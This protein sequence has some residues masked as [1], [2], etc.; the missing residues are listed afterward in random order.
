M[1]PR[2]LHAVARLAETHLNSPAAN[3]RLPPVVELHALPPLYNAAAIKVRGDTLVVGVPAQRADGLHGRGR[4]ALG[5]W[6]LHRRRLRRRR[7]GGAVARLPV[8]GADVA[9]GLLLGGPAR[10]DGRVLVGDVGDGE[11]EESH[12]LRTLLLVVPGAQA[13]MVVTGAVQPQHVVVGPVADDRRHAPLQLRGHLLHA[14]VAVQ[15]QRDPARTGPLVLRQR[16]P[17]C[18]E[19]SGALVRGE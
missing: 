10:G 14:V 9:G 15:V 19:R 3:H 8:P 1:L 5:A 12:R 6:R 16:D 7:G 2:R 13:R 17:H 4:W 11:V 18:L